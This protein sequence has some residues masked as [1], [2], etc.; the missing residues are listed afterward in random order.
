MQGLV[1]AEEDAETSKIMHI[2]YAGPWTDDTYR[3]YAD[4]LSVASGYSKS[5]EH[6]F[7]TVE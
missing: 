4:V 3:T 5:D 7:K 6:G 2:D 1:L